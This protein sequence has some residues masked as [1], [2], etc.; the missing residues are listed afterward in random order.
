MNAEREAFYFLEYGGQLFL[1]Y[2]PLVCLAALV[3]F[4]LLKRKF[5]LTIKMI[6]RISIKTLSEIYAEIVFLLLFFYLLSP[7]I[8]EKLLS[9]IDFVNSMETDPGS[10]NLLFTLIILLPLQLFFGAIL[11]LILLY[12]YWSGVMKQSYKDFSYALLLAAIFPIILI[13]FVAAGILAKK[14]TPL[15]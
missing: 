1:R 2:L 6:G 8:W 12:S 3:K 9:K 7:I 10:L 14:Y 11:N 4:Y 15:L 13:A 5:S